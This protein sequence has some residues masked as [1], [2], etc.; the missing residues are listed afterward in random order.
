MT[1]EKVLDEIPKKIVAGNSVSWRQALSDFPAPT[2]I[3]YYHLI[4]ATGLITI[5]A[6]ADGADHLVEIA[7]STSADYLAGDYEFQKVIKK[8]D[9]SE[10][11]QI[12][13]GSITVAPDYSANS[14]GLDARSFAKRTLD[15]LEALIEG[16]VQKDRANYSVHGRQLSAYSWEEIYKIYEDFKAQYAAELRKKRGRSSTVKVTFS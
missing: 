5:T 7:P 9:D 12:G 14:A 4:N 8:S 11:Y 2:W 1:F 3:L 15:Y 13:S 10:R 16:K 6:A